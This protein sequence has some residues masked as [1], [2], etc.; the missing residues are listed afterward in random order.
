[1][2]GHKVGV[3]S[4]SLK[5]IGTL[6]CSTIDSRNRAEDVHSFQNPGVLINEPA[7]WRF[8][9]MAIGLANDYLTFSTNHGPDC[10]DIFLAHRKSFERFNGALL[11]SAVRI[12]LSPK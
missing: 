11:T 6:L 4:V 2:G 1:M 5:R 12:R 3:A 8:G 10:H 9:P 7:A